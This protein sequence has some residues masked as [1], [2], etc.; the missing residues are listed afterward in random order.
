MIFK[1][2]LTTALAC[3]ALLTGAEQTPVP[4]TDIGPWVMTCGIV[5]M[6]CIIGQARALT[7]N[8][9]TE[10]I[11]AK[12]YFFRGEEGLRMLI[13]TPPLAKPIVQLAVDGN[14]FINIPTEDCDQEHC[15][16][17]AAIPAYQEDIVHQAVSIS[18]VM[19]LPE[20]QL[21][22]VPFDLDSF[23]DALAR[24]KVSGL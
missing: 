21:T 16:F 23:A 2:V 15:R 6:P 17:R 22:S 4:S 10:K 7:Q 1:S 12:L 9:G 20:D 5:N 11:L 18:V 13:E 8:D 24:L 14:K 3:A 19:T